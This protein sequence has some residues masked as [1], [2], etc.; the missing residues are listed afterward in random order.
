MLLLRLSGIVTA[1]V[2]A[3]TSSC[4]P[5]ASGLG[6]ALAEKVTQRVVV[7]GL[8]PYFVPCFIGVSSPLGNPSV[9]NLMATDAGIRDCT[10]GLGVE[11]TRIPSVLDAE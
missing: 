9:L 3:V 4:E 1:V 2:T 8:G 7:S 5:V 11:T 6:D 10:R